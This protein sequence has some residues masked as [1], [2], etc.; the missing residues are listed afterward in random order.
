MGKNKRFVSICVGLIGAAT[1]VALLKFNQSATSYNQYIVGNLIGLFFVPMLTIMLIFRENPDNF[2]FNL[3]SWRR[4]WILLIFLFGVLLPLMLI[5]S[6]W[7]GFQGY[8]PLFRW[9][10]EFALAFQNYPRVSPVDTA[11]WLMLYAEVSYGMY[12]FCWEFFFR[13]FLLFGLNRSFGWWAV[14]LQAIAFGLLHYGK[15]WIEMGASFGA[16]I[17]LGVVALNAKSF[18]P[19]FVLHWTAAVT[20]DFLI[21]GARPH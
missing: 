4:I 7:Q 9:Y 10:P 6:H 5:V 1:T 2:G 11:P 19:G 14:L 8:Y 18:M 21:I 15:P 20:F 12:M 17:I 3:G 16:G 13:G